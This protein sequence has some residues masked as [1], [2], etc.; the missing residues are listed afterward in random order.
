V[1]RWQSP[2]SVPHHPVRTF[3]LFRGVYALLA[4]DA[5]TLMLE[6]GGRYG[7][8]P[9][10]VGHFDAVEWLVPMPSPALYLA[11]VT[12]AGLYAFVGAL[13]RL[14]RAEG[15]V[16]WALY[17][18][19]W[20]ISMHDSYQHHYLLS[21]LLGF[22]IFAPAKSLRECVRSDVTA[23]DSSFPL[24]V[25]CCAVVYFFTAVSKSQSLWWR[26]AVLRKLA[27]GGGPIAWGP[28][29]L[30]ELGVAEDTAWQLAAV[31]TVALQLVVVTGFLAAL[32]RD[33]S[34][35]RGLALACSVA[36]L[37][38]TSFHVATELSPRFA[39]GW[40]S[41]YMIWVV[42]VVFLPSAWLC[43]LLASCARATSDRLSFVGTRRRAL[44]LSLVSL[45][46]AL[47][48]SSLEDLPGVG[49]AVLAFTAALLLRAWHA[50]SASSW[51]PALTLASLPALSVLALSLTLGVTH[52]RFD[53]YRRTAGE[54]SRMGRTASALDMYRA[55]ERHA[56]RGR[57]RRSQIKDLEKRLSQHEHGDA[58]QHGASDISEQRGE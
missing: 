53:Y 8:G 48:F 2:W 37:A 7:V 24:A 26:G 36:L 5:W 10:N 15:G 51:Q 17:T 16:L 12:G 28:R 23:R 6:H 22:A 29:T 11:L 9:F 27:E 55:A 46:S 41:F 18:A 1:T 45:L 47:L 19:A 58:S 50:R 3:L 32:Y 42:W 25:L 52:A 56:P 44:A 34:A 21:W 35:R 40:F 20:V 57:S 49:W 4:F 31:S 13:G 39:I 43:R 38:A 54:L 14:T 30:I 33:A